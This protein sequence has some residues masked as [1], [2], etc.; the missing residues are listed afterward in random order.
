MAVPGGLSAVPWYELTD[1]VTGLSWR[2]V[3][4][5]CPSQPSGPQGELHVDPTT[6]NPS[7]PIQLLVSA[8]NG[9]IYFLQVA[10]GILQSGLATPASASCNTAISVLAQNVVQ[11][12]EENAPPNGPVFW[13]WQLEVFTA[14][15]EALNDLTLLVGRPVIGVQ[16]P[17]NLQPNSAWQVLPKGI[18]CF[19]DIYGPQSPL[20]KVSLF[21][22]D[23]EQF[24]AGSDWE[25]DTSI[26]GPN[27][28]APIGVTMFAVHPAT[29]APQQVTAN[30]IQCPVAVPFPYTGNEVIPFHHEFFVAIEQYATHILRL[31]ESGP[32]FQNSLSLYSEYLQCAQRMS[33]IESRKDPVFFS[34]SLGVPFGTNPIQKR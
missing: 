25:N 3:V 33:V 34:L 12:L 7:A 31:K 20:R 19:T 27:T 13:N 9:T 23:Y 32:D 2:L 28:F 17:F 21:S 26:N 10:N 5:P 18:L 6:L 4:Q 8:P 30:A 22:Y 1:A 24:A 15:V 16:T 11:R 29:S 14:I